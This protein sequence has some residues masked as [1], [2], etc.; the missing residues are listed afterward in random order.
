MKGSAIHD[1]GVHVHVHDVVERQDVLGREQQR[2]QRLRIQSDLEHPADLE[3][4]AIAC[5]TCS[6]YSVIMATMLC[7][8]SFRLSLTRHQVP[9]T[10]APAVRSDTRRIMLYASPHAATPT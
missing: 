1:A 2:L 3:V 10:P 8:I 5:A 7:I 4:R 9:Q 6:W